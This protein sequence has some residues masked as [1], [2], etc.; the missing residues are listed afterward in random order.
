MQ[1][2]LLS[3]WVSLFTRFVVAGGVVFLLLSTSI[4]ASGGASA[5]SGEWI[6]YLIYPLFF[7]L[8]GFRHGIDADHIAAISDLI[9]MERDKRAQLLQGLIYAAGHASVVLFIGALTALIGFKIS[10]NLALWLEF[11]VGLTLF[12]LG[13][14]IL[15][16]V[17]RQK[18]EF[19]YKS[20]V[21]I[22]FE[23]LHRFSHSL[24]ELFVRNSTE[25]NGVQKTAAKISVLKPGVNSSLFEVF[26]AFLV[27]VLH[28]LGAE[29]PTQLTL[30]ASTMGQADY[31]L[32]ALQI[33]MFTAGLFLST[34]MVVFLVARGF[35]K[36]QEKKK[37][38]YVL[39]GVITGFYSAFLGI[40]LMIGFITGNQ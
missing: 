14:M 21:R 29:T 24:M 35:Q 37:S 27:G 18:G 7:V 17:Y 38:I 31:L 2:A 4:N 10:D 8:M 30:F 28:G 12:I 25:K 20:R 36:A 15:V 1:V 6:D 23:A 34:L 22:V 13:A 32:I 39:L 11:F 40:Y 33:V 5:A 19:Q 9:G 16:S 26:G 3:G